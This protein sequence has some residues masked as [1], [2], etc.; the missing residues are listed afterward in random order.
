[1][2]FLGL[3]GCYFLFILLLKLMGTVFCVLSY[4]YIDKNFRIIGWVFPVTIV[5][6]GLAIYILFSVWLNVPLP[7][8]F[9]A[10][11]L[12]LF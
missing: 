3:H 5:L 1:M 10:I 8:G 9:I 6:D 4:R 7:G 12:N 2:R 11:T